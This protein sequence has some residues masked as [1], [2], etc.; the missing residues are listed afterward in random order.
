M[1]ALA[2]G[3]NILQELI[4][5]FNKL[6]PARIDQLMEEIQKAK[7]IFCVG[8]GRSRIMLNAFCMRL[9]QLGFE[10]Y[11]AGNIPCPPARNGDLVIAASGSGTTPSVAVILKRAKEAGAQVALLTASSASNLTGIVDLVVNIQAPNGLIN[12]TERRESQQIMRTL[13]EQVCF[14]LEEAIIAALSADIPPEEIAA[15]HTNLE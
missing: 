14:V 3:Q 5:C 15:R 9:N 6:S 10:S 7:R 13:F 2:A 11:V 8:A 12:D 4:T 1:E